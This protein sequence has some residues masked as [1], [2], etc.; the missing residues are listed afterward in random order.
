MKNKD[1][2]NPVFVLD[3]NAYAH[4]YGKVMTL[5]EALGFTD[6]DQ[7]NALKDIVNDAF[8][9]GHYYDLSYA[10]SEEEWDKVKF[11]GDVPSI[12]PDDLAEMDV[13]GIKQCLRV[14]IS[15]MLNKFADNIATLPPTENE[16][17]LRVTIG[18]RDISIV[19]E[20]MHE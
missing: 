6:R 14:G 16:E 1:T 18:G 10:F 15:L 9:G 13:D 20:G 19:I 12:T 11:G 3:D 17:G 8:Y 4:T 2:N 7:K 5:L